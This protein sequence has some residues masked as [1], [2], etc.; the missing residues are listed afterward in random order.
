MKI[1]LVVPGFS[2]SESDWCIPAL[3]NL[4]RELAPQ[5][6]LH[7]YSL[8]YPAR[9]E[10]YSVYGATV[11]AFGG[12]KA[13]GARRAPLLAAVLAAIAREARRAPFDLFHALWADEAGFV[14]VTAGRLLDTPVVVSLMGG[15]LVGMPGIGY[16]HQ[17][18][19]A[20]RWMIKRALRGADSITVGSTFLYHLAIPHVARERL[21]VMPLGVDTSLFKPSSRGRPSGSQAILH[22]A[23]LSPVKNHDLLMRAF[24]LVAAELPDAHL[25]LVGEGPLRRPLARL[26][27]ALDIPERITFHGAI[28]HDCLPHYYHTADL[29]VLPSLYESQG[30]VTLEAA[31]SARAT[32]GTPVGL[33]PELVPAECLAL[34]GDR[35]EFA[36][37]IIDL[38]ENP[39]QR[40]RIAGDVADKVEQ[41]YTLGH[42]AR[43]MMGLYGSLCASPVPQSIECLGESK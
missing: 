21:E 32:V 16:G 25:H 39:G 20:G 33:L 43:R 4:V 1:G 14:A 12:G 30:M 8:R 9:A 38:L 24:A 34:L 17:L 11:H 19:R 18:S 42:T 13:A 5:C 35:S 22:V 7:V 40:Q 29:C 3:L 28:S 36:S 10:V 6:D 26:A 2:A 31:A 37:R 41:K 27:N 23:S 15:E